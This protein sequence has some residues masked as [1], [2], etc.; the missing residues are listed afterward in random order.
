MPERT[1]HW[2]TITLREKRIKIGAK[3]VPH[4]QHVTFQTAV[5]AVPRDLF[6]EIPCLFDG[7]RSASLP[8]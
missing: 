2:S 5:V 4:G 8:P 1:K 3:V 7:L 6:R